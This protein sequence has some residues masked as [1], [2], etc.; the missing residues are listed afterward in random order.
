MTIEQWSH[1]REGF[2][3]FSDDRLHR[4]HLARALKPDVAQMPA[5]G[6][7]DPPRKLKRIAFLMLNPSTADAFAVDPTIRRC[8]Q[9]AQ[10][11]DA[12]VLEVVNLFSL[13]TSYPEDLRYLTNEKRGGDIANNAEILSAC[14]RADVVIAAWGRWGHL[15]DRAQHVGGMLIGEGV[16][17]H[18]LK[19]LPG[20]DPSHPLARGKS[21]IPI[22]TDPRPWP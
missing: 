3:L 17:L 10:R 20:G 12:D 15:G 1:T 2:A 13:R 19:E 8:V 4:Y 16:K 6:F 7:V 5:M 11:W 21:F 9:F 18:A 14:K 22:E